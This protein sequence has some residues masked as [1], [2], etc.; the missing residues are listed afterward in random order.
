MSNCLATSERANSG[1]PMSIATQDNVQLLD[2]CPSE[3]KIKICSNEKE[4][5]THDSIVYTDENIESKIN[6]SRKLGVK[7]GIHFYFINCSSQPSQYG[8]NVC[9]FCTNNNFYVLNLS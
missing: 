5:S 3:S 7:L 8:Q 6:R 9:T 1:K 4:S 2:T